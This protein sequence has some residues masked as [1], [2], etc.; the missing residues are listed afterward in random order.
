MTF[1]ILSFLNFS[2]LFLFFKLLDAQGLAQQEGSLFSG[3]FFGIFFS[4]GIETFDPLGVFLTIFF[5][6]FPAISIGRGQAFH[7]FFEIIGHPGALPQKL[8]EHFFGLLLK[9]DHG[10]IIEERLHFGISAVN[11]FSKI[12][13]LFFVNGSPVFHRLFAFFACV[14]RLFSP[15]LQDVL[16]LLMELGNH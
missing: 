8:I 11:G 9:S 2:S 7:G 4:D 14:R 16:R 12:F 1:F 5:E 13:T 3:S 6:F 10:I 15:I